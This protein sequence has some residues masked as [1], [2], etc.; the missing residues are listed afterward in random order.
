MYNVSDVETATQVG[1][2]VY[3]MCL[4]LEDKAKKMHLDRD[5]K[6]TLGDGCLSRAGFYL[7]TKLTEMFIEIFALVHATRLSIGE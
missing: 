7:Q 6:S 1:H 5:S 2:A 3:T 4:V